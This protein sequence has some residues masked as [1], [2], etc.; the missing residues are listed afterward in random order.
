[1]VEK[2]LR[3]NKDKNAV[4]L[5]VLYILLN[6]NNVLLIVLSLVMDMILDVTNAIQLKVQYLSVLNKDFPVVVFGH[7][8]ILDQDNA[9][10]L[11]QNA[12]PVM[13]KQEQ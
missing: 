3:K 10:V 11:K 12:I 6:V 8:T 9:I 1:M 4:L 5:L 2:R 13:Q 7:K